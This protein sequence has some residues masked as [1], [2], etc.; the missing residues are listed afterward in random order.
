MCTPRWVS[1][2]VSLLIVGTTQPV[3]A[4]NF[5]IGLTAPQCEAIVG[6][7]YGNP[8]NVDTVRL[9]RHCPGEFG[10]VIAKLLLETGLIS[11]DLEAY[12][13][14]VLLAASYRERDIF[15]VARSLA[16]DSELPYLARI[17]GLSILNAYTSSGGIMPNLTFYASYSG[18]STGCGGG[19]ISGDQTTFDGESDIPHDAVAQ[20]LQSAREVIANARDAGLKFLASCIRARLSSDGVGVGPSE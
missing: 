14:I 20:A 2:V 11:S 18:P 6:N 16:E 15:H 19:G 12:K 3:V 17:A 9:V 10:R 13:E 1:V 5:D 8:A 7:A 4:Q